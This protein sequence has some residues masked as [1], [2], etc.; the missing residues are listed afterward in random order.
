MN[1]V[2]TLFVDL[3]EKDHPQIKINLELKNWNTVWEEL[4]GVKS[5]THAPD[6]VQIGSTWIGYL[7]QQGYLLELNDRIA[8]VGGA[9]A[10]DSSILKTCISPDNGV[11]SALPWFIDARGMYYREDTLKKCNLTIKDIATWDSFVQSSKIINNVE[12]GGKKIPALGMGAGLKTGELVHNVM[13]FVW[14]AG[15]D[16]YDQDTKEVVINSEASLKG[17]EFYFNLFTQG[18]IPVHCVGLD[19]AQLSVEYFQGAY[20]ICVSNVID[21]FS[22]AYTESFY[23]IDIAK[24]CLATGFPAGPKGSF[25]FAG[26]SALGIMRNSLYQKEAWEFL[27]FLSGVEAQ[28]YYAKSCGTIPAVKKAFHTQYFLTNPRFVAFTEILKTVRYYPVLSQWGRIEETMVNRLFEIYMDIGQNEGKCD[29]NLLRKQMNRAAVE[30][31][32]IL[33]T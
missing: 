16:I 31:K 32:E 27:K 14:A 28:I 26:G 17:L 4:L 24:H 3:F 20:S 9:E 6:V 15:G 12:V 18:L 21:V 10:F 11:I 25:S 22:M 1:D 7:A 29:L 23:N 19:P 5:S 13:P 8:E 30:I 33:A 2:V